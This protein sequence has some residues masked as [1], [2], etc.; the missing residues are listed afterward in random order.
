MYDYRS[1]LKE[2]KRIIIKVG[3]TSLTHDN[4]SID[5]KKIKN[6]AWV[7]TDLRNQG[8]EVILVSS[9]AIA[10]GAVR[11]GLKER[12]RDIVGK[13]AASAVGQVVLM[14]LY[15]E[16][17]L[18]Y[19]QKVA[20]ILITKSVFD[21]EIKRRNARNTME[22]LFKL[23]VIPIVN[24]NDTVAVDE[25]NEFSDNDTLSAYVAKLVAGGLLIILSDID[26]MYRGDPN[27][28]LEAEIIS[29]VTGVDDEIYSLAGG[30]ATSLG[31]GGMITKVKAAKLVNDLGIDMVI[32]SG[33]KPEDIFDIIAG[34]NI[35]TLFA[36]V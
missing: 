1:R 25:L 20:Q 23:G 15:Q 7:L 33:D 2:H 31:T 3:T 29:T 34:E 4:G 16:F 12:P 17:F 21:H 36:A 18:E 13:Q 26:G 28:N 19:N 9:G 14:Q 32:A 27:L 22:E 11:L 10:V 35:G 24:E 6:L 30:S 5:L 8:K